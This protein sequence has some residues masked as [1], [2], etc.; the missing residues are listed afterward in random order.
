MKVVVGTRKAKEGEAGSKNHPE[1][2]EGEDKTSFSTGNP[3]GS[4]KKKKGKVA[5]IARSRA[6]EKEHDLGRK[7]E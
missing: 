1:E 6:K 5:L 2:G 3:A 4:L 7:I